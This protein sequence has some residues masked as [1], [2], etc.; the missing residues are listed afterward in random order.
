MN[1]KIIR[2]STSME[3]TSHYYPE[4]SIRKQNHEFCALIGPD[5]EFYERVK[6][7]RLNPGLS[8]LV[9]EEGLIKRLP[10]NLLASYLYATDKHGSPICGNVV[11]VGER[12]S[13]DG[14]EFCGIPDNLYDQVIQ[15]VKSV[16]QLREIKEKAN[17][18]S[19]A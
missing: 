2:I 1:D 14:I 4:G 10:V 19:R 9:D 16:M 13:T 15:Y 8:M 17:T 5:C 11:I 6:P 18:S 3:M 12:M 7:L